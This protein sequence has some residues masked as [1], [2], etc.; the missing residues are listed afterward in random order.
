[1]LVFSRS[2]YWSSCTKT[3][4]R[5]VNIALAFGC[6]EACNSYGLDVA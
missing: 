1:V 4:L 5:A 3:L 2:A 6:A